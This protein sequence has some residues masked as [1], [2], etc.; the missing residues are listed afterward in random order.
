MSS[1]SFRRMRSFLTSPSS[2]VWSALTGSGSSGAFPIPA[3]RWRGLNLGPSTG[4]SR[5]LLLQSYSS[6]SFSFWPI[7]YTVMLQ[8]HPSEVSEDT[9]LNSMQ[10]NNQETCY[11]PH[12]WW[13]LQDRNK[14]LKLF[15]DTRIKAI[16]FALINRH[17]ASILNFQSLPYH[18][19]HISKKH[20]SL[21]SLCSLSP[22]LKS[23]QTTTL[24][25]GKKGRT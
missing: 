21:Y 18:W 3:S 23:R 1:W 12:L 13:S 15:W 25:A 19:F 20:L 5:S 17:I 24:L 4:N 16:C 10:T 6:F 11:K 2:S 9:L 7:F 22:P 14:S 8:Y